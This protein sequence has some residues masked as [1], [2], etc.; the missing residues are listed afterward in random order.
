M[1]KNAT[2]FFIDFGGNPVKKRR[3]TLGRGGRI[4]YVS[5]PTG[6]PGV[7]AQGLCAPRI[8]PIAKTDI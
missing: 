8:R 1:V 4:P 7:P 3:P 2:S 5:V 6:Y